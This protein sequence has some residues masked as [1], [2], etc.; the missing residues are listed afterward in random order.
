MPLLDDIPMGVQVGL[1]TSPLIYQVEGHSVFKPIVEMLYTDRL[2]QG[3]NQAVTSTISLSE[4]LVQPLVLGRSDLVQSYRDLLT[5]TTWMTLVPVTTSI[6]ERAAD[7]RAR[8]RLRLPDA[9][10]IAAA[11]EH[12]ATI[13]VT[14]DVKLRKVTD[15][16]VLVLTDYLPPATP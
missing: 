2:L 4:V 10:Q 7:M 6:A 8:F 14:N 16:T 12:G 9:V 15:L 1:D 5:A 13:F 11:L 3:N